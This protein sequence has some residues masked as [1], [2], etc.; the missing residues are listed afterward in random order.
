MGDQIHSI[1]PSVLC[2]APGGADVKELELMKHCIREDTQLY[3]LNYD[4]LD[5]IGAFTCTSAPERALVPEAFGGKF[6][7]QVFI[8]PLETP[9]LQC[10][11]QARIPAG[12]KSE[13]EL[14]K[15]RSLLEAG[16]LA[17]SEAQDAWGVA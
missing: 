4:T 13:E 5:L 8:M 15:L 17:P 6:S 2:A 3:L 11:L 14:V 12:P 10:K 9:L 16:G 7:A 1:H